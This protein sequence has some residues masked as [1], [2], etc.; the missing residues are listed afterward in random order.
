V[1]ETASER[2]RPIIGLLAGVAF[3][4]LLVKLGVVKLEF[5]RR[6]LP[7]E[8]LALPIPPPRMTGRYPCVYQSMTDAA[9]SSRMGEC[10]MLT[11]TPVVV[12][13]F[14]VDLRYGNFIVRQTDLFLRDQ[15]AVAFTR[16][17][18]SGDWIHSNLIHAFGRN[19]NHPYDI[20]L[21][22]HRNPYTDQMIALE[23]GDFVYTDRISSGS[24]YADAVFRHAETSSKFYGAITYW[25]DGG[26]TTRLADGSVI[27]FPEAYWAKR[28]A[29][30]APYEIDDVQGNKLLLKRDANRDLQEIR[31]PH[32][33]TVT[34]SYGDRGLVRRAQDDAGN[35]VTYQYGAGST[36][37]AVKASSGK[38]RYY[39]Y[40]RELITAVRD[41]HGTL[42]VRNSYDQAKLVA[43]QFPDGRLYRYR[44]RWSRTGAYADAVMVRLP[45][46]HQEE[47]DTSSSVSDYLRRPR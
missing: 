14:E 5:A 41:E 32:G 17:Y 33:H 12:D 42:L 34:L 28:M 21:L 47:V 23:D 1:S 46:G 38:E 2:L 37:V 18:N 11:L 4:G 31:T 44:Y 26:W 29:D 9:I 39:E 24:D 3:V 35:W 45:D 36:L 22:G 6:P 43:Q 7:P 40:D 13:R 8:Y 25:N 20:A 27:L 30:G 19:T 10:G 16:T 15:I